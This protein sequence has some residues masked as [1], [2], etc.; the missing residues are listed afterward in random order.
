MIFD[1]FKKVGFNSMVGVPCSYFN[2]MMNC[3]HKN[4]KLIISN[5]EGE[6]VAIAAGKKL[7]GGNPIVF[8]QNSGFGNALNPITSLIQTNKIPLLFMV[9]LRGDKLLRDEP[10][11]LIM[12][13]ITKNLF[14]SIGIR[15]EILDSSKNVKMIFK[16]IKDDISEG[17]SF[18]LIV[19]KGFFEKTKNLTKFVK[20][21]IPKTYF[22]TKTKSVKKI[23]RRNV[24]NI[25]KKNVPTK[26]CIISSTGFLSRELYSL[27]DDPRNFYM[28]GAMGCSCSISLGVA[29][30]KKNHNVICIDG[31][32]AL[33]MRLGSMSN[34]SHYRP[35]KFLH[36]LINNES[37]E[38]TG[39]QF[40]NAINVNFGQIASGF[41]YASVSV[42][43]DIET[44]ISSISWCIKNDG[45]HFI[46][47]KV[48]KITDPDFPR[49]SETPEFNARRFTN[50]LSN[51]E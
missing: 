41:N 35:K 23:S 8:F 50:Y 25:I 10:Q 29:M 32:G 18:A 47:V 48:K 33:L 11:H 5:N 22:L 1:Y 14:T 45:P 19:K 2:S 26:S 13:K 28:V 38:S 42:C 21:K 39:G 4:K 31:D 46:E 20:K 15:S 24:I 51:L 30:I 16:K 3:Y 43:D 7:A 36:F 9:S 6:A 17:K 49:P 40:S 44:L 37:H 27:G 34:I 12:G